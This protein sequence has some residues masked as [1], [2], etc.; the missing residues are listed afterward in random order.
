MW[1]ATDLPGNCSLPGASMSL[2]HYAV[3]VRSKLRKVWE[4]KFKVSM[5]VAVVPLDQYQ[6]LQPAHWLLSPE[7]KHDWEKGEKYNRTGSSSGR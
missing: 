2:C 7:S 4:S 6:Q 5:T 1:L 3:P